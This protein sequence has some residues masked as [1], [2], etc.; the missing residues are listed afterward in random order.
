MDQWKAGMF[1]PAMEK[2]FREV[3]EQGLLPREIDRFGDC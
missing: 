3:E 2:R 1:T